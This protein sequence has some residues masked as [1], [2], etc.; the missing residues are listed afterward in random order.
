MMLRPQDLVF[1]RLPKFAPWF[2]RLVVKFIYLVVNLMAV[3]P[4][5]ATNLASQVRQIASFGPSAIQ[6]PQFG[7][8]TIAKGF[9]SGVRTPLQVVV[10]NQNEW[11]TLWRRHTSID[12]TPPPLPEIDFEKYTVVGLFLGDK[13]T[14]GYEAVIVRAEPSNTD[15]VILYRERSPTGKGVVIQSLTQPFHIVQVTGPVDSRFFLGGIYDQAD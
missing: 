7:F 1:E 12:V 2:L 9:R 6:S 11:E 8:Q 3:T 13:P 15:L 4:V 10:R 14:G 5:E